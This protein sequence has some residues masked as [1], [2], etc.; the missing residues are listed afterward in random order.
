MVSIHPFQTVFPDF[1]VSHKNS[2]FT[3][4]HIKTNSSGVEANM[5]KQHSLETYTSSGASRSSPTDNIRR[6][7]KTRIAIITNAGDEHFQAHSTVCVKI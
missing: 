7:E 1:N 5:G 4:F 6:Q 2:H 3:V